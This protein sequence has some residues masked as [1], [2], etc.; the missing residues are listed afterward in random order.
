M[1]RVIDSSKEGAILG[2]KIVVARSFIARLK[3]LLFVKN[4]EKLDGMWI[5]PCHGVH[6]IGMTLSIDVILVSESFRILSIQTLRPNRIG[7]V[8][9]DALA[10]LELPAGTARNHAVEEGDLLAIEELEATFAKMT[11]LSNQRS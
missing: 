7:K 3:G 11:R 1:A 10:A 6:T 5:E 9:L 2:E 4:W 8:D